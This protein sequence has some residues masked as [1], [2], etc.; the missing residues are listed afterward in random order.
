MKTLINKIIKALR[1]SNGET[2]MEAVA[3]L[4]IL[5]ILLTSIV[6]MIRFSLVLTGDTIVT[7]SVAQEEINDIIRDDYGVGGGVTAQIIFD[8]ECGLIYNAH[9]QIVIYSPVGDGLN[10]IAFRP[11]YVP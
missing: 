10:V 3:S 4:L 6:Y 5:T 2:V 11:P 9:H 7:A 8:S 1:S